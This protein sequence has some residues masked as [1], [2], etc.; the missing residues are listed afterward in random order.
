VSLR[1]AKGPVPEK[2]VRDLIVTELKELTTGT[3]K[4]GAPYVLYQVRATYPD[5]RVI[6]D[7]KLRTFEELPTNEVIKVRIEAHSSEQFGASYTL[8]QVGGGKSA[9]EALVEKVK[10]LEQRVAHLERALGQPVAGVT[11]P[12]AV[13]SPV[14]A[15]NARRQAPIGPPMPTGAEPPTP[16]TQG[17]E[18]QNDIPF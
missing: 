6:P 14:V 7:M 8:F 17:S 10:G 11:S 3:G 15:G 5:G 2:N 13:D 16:P 9:G 12:S 4:S 18:G 1:T